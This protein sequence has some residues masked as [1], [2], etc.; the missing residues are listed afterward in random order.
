MPPSDGIDFLTHVRT[1]APISHAIQEAG[2]VPA[3]CRHR[4]HAQYAFY[5]DGSQTLYDSFGSDPYDLDN[6]A[7]EPLEGREDA[8]MRRTATHG[9]GFHAKPASMDGRMRPGGIEHP[10]KSARLRLRY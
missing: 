5:Q 4:G 6:L 9:A 3:Y 1:A 8:S 7:G 10:W 2:S